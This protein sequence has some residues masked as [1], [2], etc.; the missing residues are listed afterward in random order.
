MSE[1]WPDTR[2]AAFV[3]VWTEYVLKTYLLDCQETY[4]VS[5]IHHYLLGHFLTLKSQSSTQR[6]TT[7]KLKLG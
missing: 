3:M 2:L 4:P 7:T 1:S 5:G 6:P